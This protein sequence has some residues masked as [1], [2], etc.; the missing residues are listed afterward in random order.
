MEVMQREVERAEEAEAPLPKAL[1]P[2]V[3]ASL[4]F[5]AAGA[6]LMLEILAVRLLAPYVGLTLE[7]TTAIIGAALAGIASGAALG[8]FLADRTDTRR[9]LVV[10]L[11]LGGALA[12][13]LVPL[14]R[15]L[16]PGARG[17][18]DFVT[19]AIAFAALVPP[20]AVL[21]A[22]SPAVA[23]LQLHDLHHSGTVV[24]ALSA[25]ATAGA[26]VGTF[27]TG[28]VLIPI[29]SVSA[30][31]VGIG[32]ALI[33]VGL[34]LGLTSRLLPAAAAAGV[35][36]VAIAIGTASA[37]F[38]SPCEIETRYH[39]AYVEA[40]PENPGGYNLLLDDGYHS[41]VDLEDHT[42][43]IY[44][45][46]Q[47]MGEAIESNYPAGRPLHMVV[48]GGGGFTMP[49][50]LQATRPGSDSEV[51]ELDGELVDFVEEKFEFHRSADLRVDV[52]DARLTMRDLPADSA[53]VIIGDAYASDAVP[54]HLA[55]TEWME[56]VQR[57]LKPGGIY[58]QNILDFEP[59]KLAKAEAATLLE[60]FPDVR[61]ATFARPDGSIEGGS[62][63]LFASDRPMKEVL[64]PEPSRYAE[65]EPIAYD[66]AQVEG[67]AGDAKPLRDDY[68]PAD[69]LLTPE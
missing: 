8:G 54:W 10:L 33:L 48:V 66:K 11:V 13:A 67:F 27:G 2:V 32:A 5:V 19:L 44:P 50:W 65:F 29:M 28:F 15:W 61:L 59:L 7:A 42:R 40:D 18:G 25:W 36:V 39:C 51:L 53:E 21:S 16:G 26:L 22:V 55:T 49:L 69:Q 23:H 20:A 30:A 62:V 63:V 68:A 31:V 12:L 52:G 41:Y 4:V 24:G 35:I 60:V 47:W 6:V 43:L 3:A 9:L 57:V 17:D 58:M 1:P 38:D 14:V 56:E 34:L 64:G 46:A 37:A 45:Y